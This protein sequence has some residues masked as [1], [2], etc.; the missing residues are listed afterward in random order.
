MELLLTVNRFSGIILPVANER[1]LLMV[2]NVVAVLLVAR[3]GQ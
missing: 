1:L 2:I 3:G